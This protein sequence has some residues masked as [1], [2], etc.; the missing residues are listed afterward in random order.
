[1]APFSWEVSPGH[2]EVQAF[3]GVSPFFS[4]GSE[5]V[6]RTWVPACLEPC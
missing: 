3:E 2:R 5:F 4:E 1:M 6:L